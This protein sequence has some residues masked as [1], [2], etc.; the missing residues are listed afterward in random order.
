[1]VDVVVSVVAILHHSLEANQHHYSPYMSKI[2]RLKSSRERL[3]VKLQS[4]DSAIARLNKRNQEQSSPLQ[5]LTNDP[6]L[7]VV[8]KSSLESDAL[9]ITANASLDETH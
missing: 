7:H 8:L 1:M 9:G 2:N 6:E 4:V 5:S 3:V